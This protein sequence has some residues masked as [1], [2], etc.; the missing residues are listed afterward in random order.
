M[1][2]SSHNSG[3]VEY[4]FRLLQGTHR[5]GELEDGEIARLR[6]KYIQTCLTGQAAPSRGIDP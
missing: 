5:E 2:Q 4:S 1:S 6:V 3:H